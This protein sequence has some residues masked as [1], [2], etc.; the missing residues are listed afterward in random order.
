MVKGGGYSAP[1][2]LDLP[3]TI[4]DK[5]LAVADVFEALT[6]NDRPYKKQILLI[7]L[8]EFYHL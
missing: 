5:I 1:E 8:L 2:I 4:E 7:L 3:M 6:A